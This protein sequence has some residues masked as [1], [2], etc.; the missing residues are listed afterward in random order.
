MNLIDIWISHSFCHYKIFVFWGRIFYTKK[1]MQSL[2]NNQQRL[3]AVNLGF[4][5]KFGAF[6]FLE[7]SIYASLDKLFSLETWWYMFLTVGQMQ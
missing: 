7:F 1:T 3:F 4:Q 5:T 2:L 6:Y